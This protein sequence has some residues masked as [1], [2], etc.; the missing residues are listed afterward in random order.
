MKFRTWCSTSFWQDAE[1]AA[2]E[3]LVLFRLDSQTSFIFKT[4]SL[5]F[6]KYKIHFRLIRYFYSIQPRPPKRDTRFLIHHL[7]VFFINHST[8]DIMSCFR[9]IKTENC[10][11]ITDTRRVFIWRL[12]LNV[13]LHFIAFCKPWYLRRKIVCGLKLKKKK[14]R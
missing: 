8:V 7:C 1:N 3:L 4:N 12:I 6:L 9:N 10:S 14:S 5:F 13:Y 2:L 11:A